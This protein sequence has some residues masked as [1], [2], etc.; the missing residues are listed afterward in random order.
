MRLSDDISAHVPQVRP[1]NQRRDRKLFFM[2]SRKPLLELS[3]E[4]VLLYDSIDGRKTAA[5][6]E[7]MHPGALGRLLRWRE[8]AVV[9]LIPPISPP[10]RPHLVVIEPHMDD[11]ALSVG[12][13]L[14]HRRGLG[15]TTILS[16][17]KWSNF[18]SYLTLGR[19][20]LNVREITYLRQQESE[21]AAKLF[22]AEHH[23]LDWTDASLRFWPAERWSIA[24]AERFRHAPQ[25]FTNLVPSPRD[26]S[27]LAEQLAQHLNV[28][29][30]DELWIPMGLGNHSD[31]RTTRSA[32]LLML[33]EASNRFSSVP[34]SMYEDIPYASTLGHAAQI[35]A[36]LGGVG[37]RLVRATEDIT[38]V[39]EE[40]LHAVSVY[41][42]QFKVSSMEPVIRGLAER[43]GGA[44]GKLAEAYHCLEGEVR[45]PPESQLSRECAGL[46]ALQSGMR[47]L[48]T[49][50]TKCRR[51]TV[52][53][54]PS[55]SLRKWETD[56][57]SVVA[58]FPNA[59]FRVYVPE[60]MAWQVEEGGNDKLR[61]ELVLGRWRGWVGII[62][63]EFFRFRTPT[64][65]LWRGAYCAAPQSKVKK[66]TNVLISA[67]LPF[68]RVL[69][70]RTLWDFCCVLNEELEVKRG[71]SEKA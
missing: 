30:P 65:V 2:I 15:R 70:A 54:L 10:A 31:H 28:L 43:E 11:A 21:L 59:D 41:A 24:T 57:E 33:A 37:T 36:A 4:E 45:L 69:F 68:R 35:R 29:A 63:R 61:P 58:A 56:S 64:V 48:L 1:H 53:A 51:M 47:A 9:E 55:G 66:L 40:K 7:E 49:D 26:V 38:D 5:E 34:V 60:D 16:V 67:L 18:T 3:N 12:G 17:V 62:W 13:R 6:L 8:A 42:S 25:I 14:L 23:C 20:F 39:F 46:M 71:S 52:M 27:L 44:A 32:C 22:G 50:R 19:D